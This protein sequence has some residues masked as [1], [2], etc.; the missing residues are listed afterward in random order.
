MEPGI[1]L[2]TVDIC[3]EKLRPLGFVHEGLQRV[4]LA[5]L[6]TSEGCPLGARND[7]SEHGVQEPVPKAS[8]AHD[9]AVVPQ[10][11]VPAPLLEAKRATQAAP[12]AAIV[13]DP[14]REQFRK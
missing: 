5:R 10:H 7:D 2:V 1:K 8:A 9:A 4:V 12:V 14:V 11:H 3:C 13:A 6:A